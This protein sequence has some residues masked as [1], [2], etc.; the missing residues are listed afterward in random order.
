[1]LGRDSAQVAL[2]EAAL[3]VPL[4]LEVRRGEHAMDS[5][6]EGAVLCQLACPQESLLAQET[7][8]VMVQRGEGHPERVGSLTVWGQDQVWP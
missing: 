5:L 1:V 6:L 3:D 2:A 8:G 7:A 4:R